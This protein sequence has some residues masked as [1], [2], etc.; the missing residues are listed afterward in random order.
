MATYKSK[1]TGKRV[2][3]AVDK[4]P[5]NLPSEN[6]LIIVKADGGSSDYLPYSQVV[7]DKLDK[8]TAKTETDQIYGKL[9]D[10]SQTMFNA[11]MGAE[12]TTIPRRDTAGRVQVTDGASGTDA[13]NFQQT[14]GWLDNKLDTAGGTVTGDLTINGDLTVKG[15]ETINN[16]ENLNV[17]DAMIYTNADGAALPNFSG[18]GIKKD[19]SNVYGIVYDHQSDSVKLGLGTSSAD[20]EFTFNTDEGEPVA[21]RD[22]SSKLTNDHI[23]KWDSA[24]HK[25]VDGGSVEDIL[26]KLNIQNGDGVNSLTQKY[27]DGK[28]N[29]ALKDG[30]IAFGQNSTAHQKF[31]V[32]IGG[33]AVAGFA[34]KN[35]FNAFYYDF[36]NKKP[37]HNGQGLNAQGEVLDFA[38]TTYEN[39]FGWNRSLGELSTAKGRGAVA[40]QNGYSESRNGTAFGA[41]RAYGDNAVGTGNETS[42]VGTN[43]FTQGNNTVA[44]YDNQAAFGRFNENKEENIF[45]VGIGSGEPDEIIGL[46]ETKNGFAVLRDGR[47]KVLTAPKEDDDVVR[48]GDVATVLAL[49]IENGIGKE[50]IQQKQDGTTGTF[51]FTGKNP[52]AT[53]LD[54]TLTGQIPYGATGDFAASFGGKSAAQGKRSFS[55]NTTTIAKGNYSA[56]FGDNSVALGNDSFVANYENTAAG[57]CSAAF[58]QLTISDGEASFTEGTGSAAKSTLPDLSSGGGS[59]GSSGGS[60]GGTTEPDDWNDDEHIGNSVHVE[61]RGGT[62]YGVAAHVENGFGLGYGHFSHVGGRSSQAGN[63]ELVNGVTKIKGGNATIVH[64]YYCKGLGDYD[65]VFGQSNNVSGKWDITAGFQNNITGNGA[66][67]FGANNNVSGDYGFAHGLNNTISGQNSSALGYINNVSATH[68]TAIGQGLK[69]AINTNRVAVGAYNIDDGATFAVGCGTSDSDR[70]SAFE[71]FSDGTARIS[72]TPTNNKDLTP[73][74]YV[75][76]I[77]TALQSK[78]DNS[79]KSYLYKVGGGDTQIVNSDIAFNGNVEFTKALKVDVAPTHNNDVVR[80]LELDALKAELQAYTDNATARYVST[81]ILGG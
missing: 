35:D 65:A 64:G 34:Y 79:L 57:K 53:A 40:F 1:H 60:S 25:L 45:E 30:T 21:V 67:A 63:I 42:A 38:G 43:T 23:I 3:E 56:A 6:S 7:E 49:N 76:N 62:G 26:A 24:D 80:K 51:D 32:A 17:K 68:S 29:N 28:P 55:A 16:I 8:Q 33:G 54:P 78:I 77:Y 59:G 37:L 10:G 19:T 14:K 72:G 22:D 46:P 4:I 58:G 71:V 50:A 12:P 69:L 15:T 81:S 66:A 2:D 39:S 75:D 13:V 36:E 48:K 52:N 70:R 11:T 61:G 18:L 27:P 73:K 31:D 47:A 74:E 5:E 44:E 20:G 9:A 41:G